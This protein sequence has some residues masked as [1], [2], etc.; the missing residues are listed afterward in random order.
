M[1]VIWHE[2]ECG[3]YAGDLPLWRELAAASSGP[4][5]DVGAGLGR[6][7]LDLARCGHE[8]VALDT[9]RKLLEALDE[10]TEDLRLTTVRADARHFQLHRRFGLILVPMQ[11]VQLFGGAHGRSSFLGAACEHLDDGGLLAVAVAEDLEPFD[12]AEAQMLVPDM[13]ERDGIVYASRPVA[14]RAEQGSFV[15]ERVREIVTADGVR[16]THG[17]SVTLDRLAASELETEAV[18][19]GLRVLPRRAIEPTGEHVGSTVVMLGG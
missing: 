5:L 14:V 1:D 8:V 10:R 7:A 16:S 15:L 18:A 12:S 4:V 13:T 17:D 11:T 9:D 3:S 19:H 6:V 2:L